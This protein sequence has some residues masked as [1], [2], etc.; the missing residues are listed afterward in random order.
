MTT[1]NLSSFPQLDDVKIKDL[2]SLDP[3]KDLLRQL[4][5]IFDGE[6]QV[7]FTKMR[8]DFKKNNFEP[9]SKL[10]H[11]LRTTSLNLGFA[12]LGEVFRLLEYMNFSETDRQTIQSLF[13]AGEAES[14]I[15]H[16]KLSFYA[17]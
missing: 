8:D 5:K 9:I 10:A 11:R 15:A 4:I 17:R 2:I 1:Q 16:Q 14:Q 3:S 13:S 12:R 7:A 6:M